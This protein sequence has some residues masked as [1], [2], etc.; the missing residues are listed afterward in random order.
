MVSIRQT[1]IP[2]LPTTTTL[3]GSELVPISQGGV[4]R[5][6][7]THTLG[8]LVSGAAAM[9][10][11][12]P[13][14]PAGPTGPTGAQGPAGP[15]GPQGVKGDTGA[16]GSAGPA[17]ATG[18]QGPA[19]TNGAS[20]VT[21]RGT[22]SNATSYVLGDLVT[23]SGTGYIA[24]ASN[25]NVTPGENA[26]WSLF[27]QQGATG[28]AGPAGPTGATGPTGPKG[29][30]GAAGATG[31]TGATGPAGP[32]GP[33][34]SN[35][36]P[37]AAATVAVGTVTTGAAGSS[38]TVTNVGT[39][40]AAVLNFTIPKGD[41]GAGGVTSTYVDSGD[42]NTLSAA[43][44]YAD[45][46]GG[47]SGTYS[48]GGGVANPELSPALGTWNLNL[49][50]GAAGTVTQTSTSVSFSGAQN[51]AYA[52][53]PVTL[54]DNTS[55]DYSITISGYSGGAVR[56]LVYG[57]TSAH[58]G[59]TAS[60]SANGTFTG[61]VI[62][63]AGG[64]LTNQLRLQATGANGS[65]TLT[66]AA[67][68]VKETGAVGGT[69]PMND[70][71]REIETSVID[72]GAD[73]TGVSDSTAAF[74]SAIASGAKRVHVPAGVY[75]VTNLVLNQNIIF[76]GDGRGDTIINFTTTSTHGVDIA[77]E[78]TS[79]GAGEVLCIKD[80]RF[81]Y[82]GTGQAANMMGVWVR[83]KVFM[84]NVSVD[85]FTNH[86]IYFSPSDATATSNAVGTK[87]TIGKAVFFAR[88]D[89]V[90]SK[91]NGGDGCLIRLG[92]NAN[93]FVNCDFSNNGGSG[94]H[95]KTDGSDDNGNTGSTYGNT[96][97][98]GQASYNAQ[99]GY[100]FESGTNITTTGLYAE[101]NQNPTQASSGYASGPIDFYVG[102]NCLRSWIGIGTLFNASTTHVRVPGF[103][104]NVI[105]IWESGRRIFGDT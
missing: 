20:N 86:G 98:T 69:R 66:V 7:T 73:N 5:S 23:Y 4:T 95:H 1:T 18:P 28:P 53:V 81:K 72:Y 50:G 104:S 22:W 35:G 102:D 9:G 36:S 105:Q 43:Q 31:A 12:G 96:I 17:G 57:A 27:V 45:S 93:T 47:G 24:K 70:K 29:D 79:A 21:Y 46:V 38:A 44:A 58:L 55:Y 42:A 74:N 65:N 85:G 59:A 8:T 91:N 26:S 71:A 99:Y 88:F 62:T 30:T 78:G 76:Y 6:V 33:A 75:K 84:T 54:K 103:N 51:V 68:S 92:A 37:G 82:I 56:L 60:Y 11:Q 34:G 83:K 2:E 64:T 40:N 61:T 49:N 100:Y 80:M 16:Q 87:G 41:T 19:G 48:V 101:L 97:L 3:D 89:N 25:T 67:V 13:A 32:T 63:N 39:S 90:W 77:G 52:T 94:F 15:A 14:G 10:P